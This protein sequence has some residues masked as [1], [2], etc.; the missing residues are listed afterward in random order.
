MSTFISWF[1]WHRK[2]QHKASLKGIVFQGTVPFI[3]TRMIHSWAESWSALQKLL[4]LFALE[5]LVNLFSASSLGYNK[6][7]LQNCTLL[8]PWNIQD[9]N[10]RDP[11]LLLFVHWPFALLS[12]SGSVVRVLVGWSDL[13]ECWIHLLHPGLLPQWAG[14][15][16]KQEVFCFKHSWEPH[17]RP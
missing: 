14:K 5:K 15:N 7:L 3:S 1:T 10:S 4:G 16:T 8:T 6:L 2:I 17:S 11:D 12:Y 13:G 9:V